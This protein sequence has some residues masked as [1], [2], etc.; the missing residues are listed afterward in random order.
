M[1]NVN[2]YTLAEKIGGLI[3]KDGR[4]VPNQTHEQTLIALIIA[5]EMLLKASAEQGRAIAGL[6]RLI[7]EDEDSA[8]PA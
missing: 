3:G 4:L 8:R 1:P 2:L 7:T 5:T 6:M